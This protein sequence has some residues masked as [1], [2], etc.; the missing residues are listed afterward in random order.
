[1]CWIYS[2]KLYSD[3]L[4]I[5]IQVKSIKGFFYIQVTSIDLGVIFVLLLSCPLSLKKLRLFPSYSGYF[6]IAN[7]DCARE[8][9]P[10]TLQET[11]F[12][13]LLVRC[14]FVL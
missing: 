6:F 2:L 4:L 5:S 12:L 3:G 9:F 13:P 14:P 7:S 11:A 8:N 10:K 1:M